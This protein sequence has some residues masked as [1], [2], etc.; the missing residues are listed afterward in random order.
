MTLMFRMLCVLS[1]RTRSCSI[2]NFTILSGCGARLRPSAQWQGPAPP[3]VGQGQ[4][5]RLN[6]STQARDRCC[7][8]AGDGER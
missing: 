8:C 7:A 2:V 1:I 3:G 4:E 5:C 6:C